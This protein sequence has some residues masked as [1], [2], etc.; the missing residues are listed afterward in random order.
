MTKTLPAYETLQRT[1]AAKEQQVNQLLGIMTDQAEAL[2]ELSKKPFGNQFNIIGSTITNLAGSGQIEYTEAANQVRNL[3]AHTA[4]A[5]QSSQIAQQLLAQIQNHQLA[6]T[7]IAQVELIRQII[8]TEAENDPL[9]KQFILQQSVNLLVAM[10]QG[11]IVTA[12]QTAL[13]TLQQS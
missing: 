5:S 6:S 4:D 12:F 9:F 7:P 8:L 10:P 3:V 1:L 11:P 2:K 13:E